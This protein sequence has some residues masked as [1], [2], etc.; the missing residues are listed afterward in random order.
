[1]LVT[2][3]VDENMTAD[4]I[5]DEM[6]GRMVVGSVEQIA[7]QIKTNVLDAGIDGVIINMPT[8]VQGYQPGVIA[9]LGQALK[10]LVA[11]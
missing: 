10:P 3:M 9:A 1:M 11:G 8:N 5:P 7:E 6:K 2:A 4:V